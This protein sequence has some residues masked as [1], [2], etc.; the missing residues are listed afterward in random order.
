[1]RRLSDGTSAL[2]PA[3][4][5]PVPETGSVTSPAKARRSCGNWSPRPLGRRNAD[6]RRCG[7]LRTSP[8]GR[9][10]TEEDRHGG[11]GPRPRAC[12]VGDAEAWN[13]VAGDDWTGRLESGLPQKRPLEEGGSRSTTSRS[14]AGLRLHPEVRHGALRRR[15][16]EWEQPHNLSWHSAPR[17]MPNGCLGSPVLCL[18]PV[19]RGGSSWMSDRSVQEVQMRFVAR[20][21]PRPHRAI[22]FA[23][24]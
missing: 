1:M 3:K 10:A 13:D 19:L 2:C 7:V 4:I 24:R 20:S 17:M 9:P 5:N 18:A 11:D 14:R 12:D 6:R 8:T 23:A 16:C 15:W 22:P 21:A